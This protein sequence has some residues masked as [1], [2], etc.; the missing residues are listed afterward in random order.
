MLSIFSSVDLSDIY[1][2]FFLLFLPSKPP[3]LYT[4]FKL[5][6]KK[7]YHITGKQPDKSRTFLI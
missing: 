2:K 3:G 1:S 6:M 7:L 5:M 4:K